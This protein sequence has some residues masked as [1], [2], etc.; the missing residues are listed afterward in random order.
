MHS[1]PLPAEQFNYNHV[2]KQILHRIT[3]TSAREMNT[4]LYLHAA[5][6]LARLQWGEG[7]LSVT[8][9]KLEND[10]LSHPRVNT[11]RSERRQD[12]SSPFP[13]TIVLQ[14]Y[15]LRTKLWLLI[16]CLQWQHL[17]VYHPLGTLTIVDHICHSHTFAE[18]HWV[19]G[20]CAPSLSEEPVQ[21][22]RAGGDR[23]QKSPKGWGCRVTSFGSLME[24]KDCP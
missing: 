5:N 6:T 22:A 3:V 14:R 11:S 19:Q 2:P 7:K 8:S 20:S 24:K 13:P 15:R 18:L 10:S 1:F 16:P 9:H 21:H 4:N 23:G 12:A 17:D